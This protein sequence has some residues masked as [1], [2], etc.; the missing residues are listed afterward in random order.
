[1]SPFPLAK[2]GYMALRQAGKPLAN[3]AKRKAKKSVFFRDRIC[4]PV[5]QVY[6]QWDTRMKMMNLGFTKPEKGSIKPLD[7]ALAVD[8]GAEMIGEITVFIIGA[9]VLW[10]EYWRQSRKADEKQQEEDNYFKSLADNVANLNIMVE[11]QDAQLRELNRHVLSLHGQMYGIKGA[12]R[13]EC[14]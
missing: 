3:A 11:R 14:R 10:L 7:E 4:V 6:H 8:L 2:L 5:A 1:M 12:L 9:A 13:E